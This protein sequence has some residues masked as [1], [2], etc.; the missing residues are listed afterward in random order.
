MDEGIP[1]PERRLAKRK[2]NQKTGRGRRPTLPRDAKKARLATYN[3][4][5]ITREDRRK[6]ARNARTLNKKTPGPPPMQKE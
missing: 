4:N 1:S 3:L 6:R 2:D 5:L